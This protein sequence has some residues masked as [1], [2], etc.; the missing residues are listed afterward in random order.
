M[1]FLQVSTS[2]TQKARSFDD[3]RG[4]TGWRL[5]YTWNALT[6][7]VHCHNWK[8][9]ELDL[10]R[11]GNFCLIQR[12]QK[13]QIQQMSPHQVSSK[14]HSVPGLGLIRRSLFSQGFCMN[15]LS[16]SFGLITWS[17][18][19]AFSTGFN[20]TIA[21]VRIPRSF[22]RHPKKQCKNGQKFR[23]YHGIAR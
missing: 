18:C 22:F 9:P 11:F 15:T 2:N 12:N 17:T 1:H 19:D 23:N 4:N 16:C 6:S 8:R 13:K 14:C 20:F 21:A 3:S 7:T 5:W 10:V